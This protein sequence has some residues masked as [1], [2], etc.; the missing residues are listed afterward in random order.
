MGFV[1]A[2]AVT[3]RPLSTTE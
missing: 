3:D 2:Q 1:I